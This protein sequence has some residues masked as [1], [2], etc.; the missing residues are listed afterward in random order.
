MHAPSYIYLASSRSCQLYS[1][2]LPIETQHAPIHHHHQ[3]NTIKPNHPIHHL[4]TTPQPSPLPKDH[5]TDKNK[6]MISDASLYS[7]ALLLGSAA[8][9]MI[10]LYHFLEINSDEHDQHTTTSTNTKTTTATATKGPSASPLS[11][12]DNV[13]GGGGNVG[14]LKGR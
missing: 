8:M 5:P 10:I 11:T 4:R 7:L 14:S 1:S 12:F 9:L 2:T 13:V 6:K 3:S